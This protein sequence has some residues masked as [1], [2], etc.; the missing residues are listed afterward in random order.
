MK[1]CDLVPGLVLAQYEKVRRL[2]LWKS[3]SVFQ[4][5]RRS[6]AK[7]RDTFSLKRC[8]SVE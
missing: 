4:V 8:F 6:L 7:A 5:K 3:V 1:E 2:Y